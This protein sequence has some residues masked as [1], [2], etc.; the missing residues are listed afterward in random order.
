M[1]VLPVIGI[2]AAFDEEEE[3]YSLSRYYV[4]AVARAGGIPLIVPPLSF[5]MAAAVL[6]KIQGLLL[7]GGGDLDPAYFGEEPLPYTKGINPRRDIFELA[8]ARAALVRQVPVLGIC[9]GMQVLNVA[10]GGTIYQDLIL[11]TAHPLKHY[12][13]APRWYGTHDIEIQ[14]GSKLHSVLGVRRLRVNSFHHQAVRQ[15][16]P[17]FKISALARD[18][19]VEGIELGNHPFVV[20]VQFHPEGMWERE[21]VFLGLFTALVKAA[22]KR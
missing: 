5:E 6:E 19:V 20:G 4:E 18:G 21:P 7:S 2:T 8:L 22:K 9:R 17:G 16:A 10:A 11:G 1:T 12:Q 13:E 15:I 3:R 14:P